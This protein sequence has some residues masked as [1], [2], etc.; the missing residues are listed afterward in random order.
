M[1][2]PSPIPAASAN[3]VP[4]AGRGAPGAMRVGRYFLAALF[5]A[6][7]IGKLL[8]NRGFAGVIANYQLGLP[9][10]WLLPLGLAVSLAELWIGARL[11]QGRHIAASAKL[12]LWFHLG[13]ATLAL[14]TLA[15]GIPLQNCGCFGVFWARPLRPGTVVEDVTLAV[16]SWLVWRAYSRLVAAE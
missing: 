10:P 3:D 2:G 6:T 8:D 13:Y 11:L 14:L 15:R 12:T 1:T 7:A 16:I 4:G 9:E 5:I